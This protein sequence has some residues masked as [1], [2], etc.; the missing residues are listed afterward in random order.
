MFCDL[1]SANHTHFPQFKLILYEMET[2]YPDVTV[3]AIE[4]QEVQCKAKGRD[5]KV[6]REI[7]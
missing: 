1:K 6:V 7:V 4:A 3:G 5:I 2:S